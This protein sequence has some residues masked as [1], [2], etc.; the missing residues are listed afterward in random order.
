[1]YHWNVGYS[2]NI[3]ASNISRTSPSPSQILKQSLNWITGVCP[4]RHWNCHCLLKIFSHLL[5]RWFQSREYLWISNDIFA[6]WYTAACHW[7]SNQWWN[8]SHMHHLASHMEQGAF[9]ILEKS[10]KNGNKVISSKMYNF[11]LTIFKIVPHRQPNWNSFHSDFQDYDF[12]RDQSSRNIRNILELKEFLLKKHFDPKIIFWKIS[13][14]KNLEFLRF[15][16]VQNLNVRFTDFHITAIAKAVS[17]TLLLA[18]FIIIPFIAYGIVQSI[19]CKDFIC[20]EWWTASEKIIFS[21]NRA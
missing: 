6:L 10:V 18:I 5:P 11:F 9:G 14:Y 19:I 8:Q 17:V 16:N 3:D 13:F 20:V 12:R 2:E 7:P 4:W 21:I 15:F 1:M